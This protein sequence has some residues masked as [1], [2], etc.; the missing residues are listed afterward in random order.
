MTSSSRAWRPYL[1]VGIGRATG[2]GF[3]ALF[4][5]EMHGDSR[6]SLDPSTTGGNPA[7][8]YDPQAVSESVREHSLR[9]MKEPC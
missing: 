5:D 6:S 7:M 3:V 9:R 2:E 1:S 4:E 8:P